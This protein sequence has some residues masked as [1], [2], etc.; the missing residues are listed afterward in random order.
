[1]VVSRWNL[2]AGLSL[3]RAPPT[4]TPTSRGCTART[5]AAGYA[6]SVL[7]PTSAESRGHTG[8]RSCSRTRRT[9]HR[10][11]EDGVFD[12]SRYPFSRPTPR[13]STGTV[14]LDGEEVV[15]SV[16][17]PSRAAFTLRNQ[18]PNV[19]G[20]VV[21]ILPVE[22][23]LEGT[24]ALVDGGHG[25]LARD[26]TRLRSARPISLRLECQSVRSLA[27]SQCRAVKRRTTRQ[28]PLSC[29]SWRRPSFSLTLSGS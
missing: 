5:R 6:P 23:V 26:Q 3:D 29:A 17:R 4:A 28:Y 27:P 11:G 24:V 14:L 9:G 12:L 2:Y 21:G 20:V 7:R 15:R 10:R 19:V 18:R 8:C 1:M 13:R 25:R 22:L 16:K